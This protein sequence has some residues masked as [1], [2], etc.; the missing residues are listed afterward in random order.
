[1]LRPELADRKVLREAQDVTLA[2]LKE[3]QG[4]SEDRLRELWYTSREFRSAEAQAMI[5]DAARGWRAQQSVR[6]LNSHRRSI[7]PVQ[8]PGVGQIRTDDT[9]LGRRFAKSH[10]ARDAAEMLVAARRSA[11]RRSR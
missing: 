7:P 5:Y 11:A 1:M 10:S 9:D 3:A 2:Y 4:L 6:D 8:R